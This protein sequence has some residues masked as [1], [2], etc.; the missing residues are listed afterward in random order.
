MEDQWPP[1]QSGHWKWNHAWFQQIQI[2]SQSESWNCTQQLP[3]LHHWGAR[4]QQWWVESCHWM[5]GW[6][7]LDLNAWPM[8]RFQLLFGVQWTLQ[9]LVSRTSYLTLEKLATLKIGKKSTRRLLTGDRSF[10]NF[11]LIGSGAIF[12][13]PITC[14]KKV[15]LF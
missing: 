15:T 1:S 13:E 7:L 9:E 10:F 2:P 12:P 11:S 5:I 14:P 8:K 6:P 3:W 4:W